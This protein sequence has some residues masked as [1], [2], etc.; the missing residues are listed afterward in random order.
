MTS[1]DFETLW[2][3]VI[4][5]PNHRDR[6]SVHGPDHWR[7]VER[8]GCILAARSGANINVVRLFALFHD[9]RRENDGW[10]PD[11]GKR[12]A[13][14]ASS[15]RGRHFDLPDKDFELL[16]YACIWHTDEERHEDSTI[17]TCW[18]ADRLDL[19]R[20]GMIPDPHY[21]STSFGAEIAGHGTI[22]PWIH[23]AKAYLEDPMTH[24]HQR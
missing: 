9:S 17:G 3:I 22:Q 8:N 24:H 21:M 2:Q 6:Y 18:D 4:A 14:L 20:V 5:A 16:H 12:G 11:H 7:R 10:D 19:G 1:I 23:L 15:M 13:E